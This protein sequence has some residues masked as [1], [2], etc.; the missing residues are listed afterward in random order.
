MR[1]QLETVFKFSF[2]D[3][4]ANVQFTISFNIQAGAPLAV[5]PSQFTENATVG[6]A[7]E[8]ANVAVVSGGNPPYS[9]PTVDPSSP[10]QLPPGVSVSIDASGNI[11][12]S[13]TPTAAGTGTVILDIADSG[14]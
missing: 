5:S 9:Q 7:I 13:G 1:R 10:N 6:Q 4:M 8:Q 11:S 12:I 2:G 14:Q 3:F